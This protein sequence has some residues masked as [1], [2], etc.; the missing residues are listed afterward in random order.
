MPKNLA[1]QLNDKYLLVK[2]NIIHQLQKVALEGKHTCEL[3]Y[4]D[5]ANHYGLS[6]QEIDQLIDTFRTEGLIVRVREESS[7]PPMGVKDD[8]FKMKYFVLSW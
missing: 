6:D 1:D 4:G 5:L 7:A 2:D 3:P 8:G